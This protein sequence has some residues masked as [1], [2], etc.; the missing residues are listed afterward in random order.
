MLIAV[1]TS[2]ISSSVYGSN[3]FRYEYT[4]GIPFLTNQ[5]ISKEHL[6]YYYSFVILFAFT[7]FGEVRCFRPHVQEA[8]FLDVIG[9][10]VFASL[11][12]IFTSK[13]NFLPPPPP[14]SLNNNGLKLVCSVKLY[15]ET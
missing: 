11:L 13:N 2:H 8:E 9:T 4:A 5:R 15:M 7:S 12:F 3:L 6:L 14:P 10:K 1:K